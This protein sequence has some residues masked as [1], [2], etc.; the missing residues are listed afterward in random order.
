MYSCGAQRSA[1][2]FLNGALMQVKKNQFCF[3]VVLRCT[4]K[5]HKAG[6]CW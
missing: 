6:L 1:T 4:N 2:L 5:I 3:R